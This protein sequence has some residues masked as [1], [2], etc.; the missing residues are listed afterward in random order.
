MPELLFEL[1]CEEIP[2]EDLFV[3]PQE[4]KRIA[5]KSFEENRLDFSGLETE[6]TPRRLVLRAEIEA[7]Q[8]DLRE[9]KTGPPKR[10]AIDTNGDPTPAGLGF[11][12]N[13]GMP[14]TKLKF[15]TTPKGEYLS[16]EILVKG[17][18]TPNI[19]KQILPSILSQLPFHKF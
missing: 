12:K 5:T 2:A 9:E 1:G 16:A 14:F 10:V 18:P 8:K 4:L 3:L 13:C 17:K 19:L 6:T 7:M 15:V 11:A